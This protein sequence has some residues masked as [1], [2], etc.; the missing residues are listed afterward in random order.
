[1]LLP[2]EILPQRIVHHSHRSL[3][4]SSLHSNG[5]EQNIVVVACVHTVHNGGDCR[6][7]HIVSNVGCA[8]RIVKFGL[9]RDS[10]VVVGKQRV[11]IKSTKANFGST[12]DQL[13]MVVVSSSVEPLPEVVQ[14]VPREAI[15]SVAHWPAQIYRQ[16]DCRYLL[17]LIIEKATKKLSHFSIPMGDD[18]QKIS[19]AIASVFPFDSPHRQRILN[20]SFPAEILRE[21]LEYIS[22]FDG[23]HC[24]VCGMKLCQPADLQPLPT[25]HY[26][27]PFATTHDLI[28]VS[29]SK[30][31]V[32]GEAE[33]QFSWFEGH[34]WQL[35]YCHCQSHL[36]WKFAPV[37]DHDRH[38]T[39]Q[40]S[41]SV[42]YCLRRSM[43]TTSFFLSQSFCET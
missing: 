9:N 18:F 35:L 38:A 22:R 20:F 24:I 6:D 42:F 39:L 2:G 14:A 41:H 4:Y 27:N 5:E 29:K 15:N 16:F 31:I 34:T 43:I 13:G 11:V 3:I 21:E 32:I 33:S 1:M 37:L 36:G 10:F 25:L 23:V 17:R 28:K 19:Y 8:A 26:V 7:N 40:N 30:G 12:F